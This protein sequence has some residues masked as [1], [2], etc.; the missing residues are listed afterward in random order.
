MGFAQGWETSSPKSALA[1]FLAG[2]S[3]LEPDS[4]E[5]L[6]GAMLENYVV[7]N[8]LSIMESHSSVSELFFWNIQGRSEVDLVLTMGRIVAAME[9][10]LTSRVTAKM[11]Q[12][13]VS[14]SSRFKELVDEALLVTLAGAALIMRQG[15]R[16][17]PLKDLIEPPRRRRKEGGH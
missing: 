14:F 13:L 4:A 15:V 7:Q 1:C 6:R 2:V 8:L 12:P 16:T 9:V 3:D 17:L 5:P 11:A 10:K